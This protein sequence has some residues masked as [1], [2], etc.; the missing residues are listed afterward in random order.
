MI[1]LQIFMGLDESVFGQGRIR[2][3]L[4]LQEYLFA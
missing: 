4:R 3:Q 2:G 1:D